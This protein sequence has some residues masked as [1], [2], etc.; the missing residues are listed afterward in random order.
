MNTIAVIDY[1]MGN[2]RSV[3]KALEFVAPE[4]RVVVT[5]DARQ[6]EAAERVLFPGVGALRDCM[7]ELA[8]LELIEP[9]R[10][11][12]A[13]KPFMG[14]C[15]GMQA[16]LDHSEENG[17]TEGLGIVP[18]R[19]KRF[20]ISH[21]DSVTGER[22]KIPHMGWNEVHQEADHPMWRD[23]EQDS[24]FYFVHSYY[25]EPQRAAD[26]AGTTHYGV[27]FASAIAVGNIFA[28]QFHPEKSQQAGLTLLRNFVA[29]NGEI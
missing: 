23:I 28:A 14:I 19:V 26:R 5:S 11:A 4:A 3:A 1:G 18:G 27:D 16:L 29:W 21:L 12:A 8:R 24:R 13:A 17:G 9:L 15:L 7:A 25:V 20:D 22:L 6:I 10:R 2:L